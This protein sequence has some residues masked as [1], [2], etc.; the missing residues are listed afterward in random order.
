MAMYK[1][2][3][4]L[5][6]LWEVTAAHP[7]GMGVVYI[8]KDREGN[9]AAAKTV[10]D[11]LADEA[12]F[13]RRFAV[14]LKT[15]LALGRHPNLVEARGTF[16]HGGR[17]FLLLE[18]VQGLTLADLLA[19]DGPLLPAEA[20]DYMLGLCRGME[21]AESSAVGPGGRGIVHRDLKPSNLFV[22][23]ARRARVSDFGMVKVFSREGSLTDE[24]MGLGTPYYVSPEQLREAR[25]TDGRGDVY[26]AGAILYEALAGEPP[27][28]AETI[29]NQVYN[30]LRVIPVPPSLR[31]P[32][33]PAEASALVLRCLEKDREKRF[34]NFASLAVAVAA[35]LRTECA[36]PLPP[37][38]ALCPGCGHASPK[39]R[40]FCPLDGRVMAAAGPGDRYAP[41]ERLDALAAGAIPAPLLLRVDGVEVRPRVPR[42]GL[43][44]T[45]TA[46]LANPGV[47]AVPG[48]VVPFP[49]PDPD[50]FLRRG[51]AEFWRGEV[52]PTPAGAPLRISYE[53]IPLRE[54]RF[55]APVARALWRDRDGARREARAEAVVAFDVE[56]HAVLPL[57][58]REAETA[59]LRLCMDGA[60]ARN[61]AALLF[62]GGPG[63]GKT[64]LLDEAAA[65]AAERGFRVLRGRGIERAGQALRSLHEAL[66]SYFGI[67]ASGLRREEITARVVDGLDP[68][69]GRDPEMVSFLSGFLAGGVPK[70]GAGDFLWLRFFAGAVRR[71]PLALLLD[72][73][74]YGEFETMDL[75]EGLALRAREE[76]WPLLIVLASRPQDPDARAVLRIRHLQGVRERLEAGGALR[77]H[78]LEPLG[79][80]DVSRLLDAAFPGNSFEAEAPFLPGILCGQ[81]GGN[82]FFLAE[83]FQFLRGARGPD[84]ELLVAPVPGGWSV[85]PTLGPETLREFVPGAVEDAVEG[86]LRTLPAAALEV[87][88]HAAVVGEEFEVDVLEEV[89]GGAEPVERALEEMERA[90]IVEAVDGSLLRY[91]FTH[92]LLPHVVERRIGESSPRRLRRLHG[93]VADALVH[94][95]GKRGARVL[96]LRLS[97]HLLQA[98]RRREAFDALVEAAGRLVRAQL[99]PRAA[100]TLGHAQELLAGGLKPPRPRLRDYHMFRGETSRILGRYDEAVESFKAAIETASASGRRSD[101]DLLATAYSKMGEVHEARGQI[102]DALYCYGVGMGLREESGDR[103]GLANSLVNIGTAYALAGDRARAKDFLMRALDLSV[104]ARNR[105]ARAH[106]KIQLAGLSLGEGDLSG[107]RKWYR[108]GLAL[109]KG[110]GDRRGQAMALNGLGNTALLEGNAPRADRAYRRSLEMRRAI[111]DREGMSN[112]Y[113]NL[114]IVAERRGDHR[115]A[116][117]LYRKSLALHRSV[118]SVRGIAIASQNL[119]EALLRSGDPSAAVEALEGSVEGW[120]SLGD[121]EHLALARVSMGKALEAAGRPAEAAGTREAAVVDAEASGSRVARATVTAARAEALLRERKSREAL[122]LL[123]GATVEGLPPETEA[124]VRLVS[125]GALLEGSTDAGRIDAALESAR[126]AVERALVGGGDPDLEVRL[127]LGRGLRAEAAGAGEGGRGGGGDRPLG[128][129]PP[130]GGG[131][132]GAAAGAGAAAR[133]AYRLAAAAAQAGGRAPGPHLLDALRGLERRAPDPAAAQAARLRLREAAEEMRARAGGA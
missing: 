2:G 112:S 87:L 38:T 73:L 24:G 25:S 98:D 80:S 79:P 6:A 13:V 122:A 52:R 107:A 3:D 9:L 31:N 74:H 76:G 14:E 27:L 78:D 35:I 8:L 97:R 55:E 22:T 75:V 91:R 123:D 114:G 127:L 26:S 113:N 5:T 105:F 102:T 130:P 37:G 81:T 61:P 60:L 106:S 59:S 44:M 71:E 131:R 28:K 20:L 92:S 30:I 4:R 41:V 53:V 29:E 32:A 115:G 103:T 133:E 89:A 42:T 64:R 68:L 50:A 104:R 54:G 67:E 125:L 15:W 1:P 12:R 84:G 109:F 33:V 118:G 86:H 72:D 95:H 99:F 19:A 34:P 36:R 100:S 23:P 62:F 129:G 18:Y 121:R 132:G 63:M 96:G 119:G 85:S 58:G 17:P 21:H 43:P 101:R 82:P 128:G 88:E 10:R 120:K 117:G 124:E 83:T 56:A 11:E 46:L 65:E 70:E 57:V 69:L 7:G 47:D 94:L 48:C 111:G 49:L 77:V 51:P 126:R 40:E 45:I 90:G 116:V 39:G 108:R 16:E 93:E 66:R 110:L